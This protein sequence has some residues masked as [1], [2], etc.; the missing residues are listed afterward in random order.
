M[1]LDKKNEI[2]IKYV[3]DVHALV[4]HGVQAIHR[5]VA[6]L[7]DVSHQDA[8]TAVAAF[9]R[10]LTQQK[11]ELEAR[12]KALGGSPTQPVKDAV[13]AV[14]GVAAG[15]INAVRPSETA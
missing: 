8:K 11:T 15:V 6:N 13:S 14:A 4:T 5:Q 3:T 12:I 10:I 9:E 7:K 2:L 1:A